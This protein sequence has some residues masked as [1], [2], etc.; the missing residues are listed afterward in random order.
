MVPLNLSAEKADPLA[1]LPTDVGVA[2]SNE[3]KSDMQ[4]KDLVNQAY[5]QLAIEHSGDLSRTLVRNSGLTA[6]ETSQP[7]GPLLQD[8]IEVDVIN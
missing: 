4:G 2:Q 5:Q 7:E 6:Q 3:G 8:L 1:T